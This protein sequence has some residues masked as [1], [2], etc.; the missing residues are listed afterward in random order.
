MKDKEKQIEEMVNISTKDEQ[1]ARVKRAK[2]KDNLIKTLLHYA[3]N[4]LTHG[5]ENSIDCESCANYLIDNL[6][7]RKINDNEIVIS[8]KDKQKLLHEMYEQGRFDALAD[9]D[10]S[11]KVVISKKELNKKYVSVEMYELAKAFHDEKCAEF[12]K[13]CYNYYKLRSKI[14]DNNE[15]IASDIANLIAKERKETAEKILKSL[16]D[17]YI[18]R[19]DFN[20]NGYGADESITMNDLLDLAEQFGVEI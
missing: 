1:I 5:I 3:N 2:E 9:L 4:E 7:Y 15:K 11:G 18:K 13:L 8:K 16:M 19:E 10:K 17:K 6:G 14:N 20:D 12:E